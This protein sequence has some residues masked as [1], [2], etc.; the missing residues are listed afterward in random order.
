MFKV[1]GWKN[2]FQQVEPRK[3]GGVAILIYDKVDFKTKLVR[4]KITS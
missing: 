3:Q 4:R 2:I 1:K